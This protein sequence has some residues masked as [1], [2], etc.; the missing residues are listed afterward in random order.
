[1]GAWVWV[2]L[3]GLRDPG[4][5]QSPPDPRPFPAFPSAAAGLSFTRPRFIGAGMGDRAGEGG[6]R[7]FLLDLLAATAQQ[8]PAGS[9]PPPRMD[10]K[11]SPAGPAGPAPAVP[12]P[13][14]ASAPGSERP[15]FP[16]F[17]QLSFPI[18]AA[19]E[20]RRQRGCLARRD[21]RLAARPALHTGCSG[22]AALRPRVAAPGRT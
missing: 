13:A 16:P 19:W 14:E 18:W 1:M 6:E 21:L 8:L 17:R 4:S 7:R 10:G 15:S 3:L 2:L 20:T 9:P 22:S 5:F 11:S 12:C